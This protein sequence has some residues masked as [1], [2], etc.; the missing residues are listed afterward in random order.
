[1]NALVPSDANSAIRLAEMMSSAK[2]VPSHLQG[3]SGDCLLV[4]EQAMR[5]GMSPFAVAQCTSVVHGR[6]F[7][8]GKLVAA[9]VNTSGILQGRM[10]Y[11]FTGS[12]KDR[13]VTATALLKG[14]TEPR[15]VEV[16][17]A[18]AKTD[19]AHWTKSPDQMLA[20]HAARVWTRRHAPEVM[21]GVYTPEEF[22]A[23]QKPADSFTGTTIEAAPEPPRQEL[24]AKKGNIREWLE[25]FDLDTS[26]AQ[27]PEE[28]N[29]LICSEES[30]R[31][32]DSLKGEAKKRYDAIVHATL[33][34]W[35]H[36]RPDDG[37]N[38]SEDGAELHKKDELDDI[39]EGRF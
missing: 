3:K 6:L 24:P 17:L 7:F 13:A 2:L 36:E 1:M 38:A 19:N 12:G 35:Y 26:M 25:K 11:T 20:Y 29:A 21:L 34:K 31:A 8:E 28:A 37:S 15:T 5:W 16:T 4:I 23:P 39:L 27:S 9:A 33:K 10:N 14:E 30:L 32:K 22:D 18:S